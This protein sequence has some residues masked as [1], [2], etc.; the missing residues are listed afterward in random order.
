[1]YQVMGESLGF[2]PVD[3]VLEVDAVALRSLLEVIGPVELDG[4]T[5]DASNV[6]Q[7]VLN[8][9][10]LRFDTFGE[11]EQRVSVQANLAK[12]IFEAFKEREVPVTDL[13]FALRDAAQGR[14]LL[15]RSD[16]PAVQELWESV[17]ADG[18]LPPTGLMVAVENIGGNK[19]DWFVQPSVVV[20]VLPEITGGWKARVTVAVE[21]PVPPAGPDQRLRAGRHRGS[22]AAQRPAPGVRRGVHAPGGLRRPLARRALHRA[23]SG[24]APRHGG[25][26]HRRPRRARP[27]GWPWSSRSLRTGSGP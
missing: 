8:E 6:E 25:E 14:H 10:Y 13:A 22:S 9:S 18:R 1:M 21:N 24:P 4:E 12:A 27:C 7:K 20:N 15:A 5:Y 11:R 17:G 3:G 26:A 19:L 2:G 16:D 23:G